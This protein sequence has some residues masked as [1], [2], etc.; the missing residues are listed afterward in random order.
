MS[1]LPPE[2]QVDVPEAVRESVRQYYYKYEDFYEEPWRELDETHDRFENGDIHLQRSMFVLSYAY[3]VISIQTQ[4]DQTEKM[5]GWLYDGMPL[6]EV[7]LKGATPQTKGG[8]I[9][10]TLDRYWFAGIEDFCDRLTSNRVDSVVHDLETEDGFKYIR[11]VKA[12]FVAANLGYTSQMCIDTNVEDFFGF[13][14]S[15]N[16]PSGEQVSRICAD[17]QDLFPK[18]MREVREPYH[19]QWIL[20]NYERVNNV[21]WEKDS[22]DMTLD[23]RGATAITE[24]EGKDPAA[25]TNYFRAVLDDR[26]AVVRRANQMYNEARG[27]NLPREIFATHFFTGEGKSGELERGTKEQRGR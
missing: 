17:I 4:L 14:F 2:F 5:F 10:N 13:D 25:H 27:G 19:L 18:L 7:L 15:E 9:Y 26:D 8:Y 1:G 3:T 24:K 22:G 21:H 6:Y 16:E 23:V 20:F 12:P 11:A